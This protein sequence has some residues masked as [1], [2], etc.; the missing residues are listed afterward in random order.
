MGKKMVKLRIN[1]FYLEKWQELYPESYNNIINYNSSGIS[2]YIR[3]NPIKINISSLKDLLREKSTIIEELDNL[4]NAA[5]VKKTK[6]SIG[7]THEYL[8]GFYSVQGL[9]SQIPIHLFDISNRLNNEDNNLRVLDMTSAPGNKC[10]QL[11]HLLQNKHPLIAIEISE[12]RINKLNANLRRLGIENVLVLKSNANSIVPR[13]GLFSH[14]L[15]DAPCTGSGSI[16]RDP[17]RNSNWSPSKEN[18]HNLIRQQKD[19]LIKGLEALKLGGEL[20]YSTC[21]IEP[22]ENEDVISFAIDKVSNIEIIDL[23]KA[24]TKYKLFSVFGNIH[25]DKFKNNCLRFLPSKHHEGF[26]I[27]KLKKKE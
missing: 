11:A 26:F 5:I 3:S 21:S 9:A 24:K 23:S 4:P 13:L 7:S 27:C 16:C 8:K 14:I 15:L 17:I 6:I 19:L 10:S 20:I 18:F 1:K 25:N 22:E 12:N 2:T